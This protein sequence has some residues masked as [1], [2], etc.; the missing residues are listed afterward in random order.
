MKRIFLI[1]LLAIAVACASAPISTKQTVVNSF[2][3][4]T[5][6]L[7]SAQTLERSY[8]FNS[9]ATES[10]THCTNPLAAQIKLTDAL[11]VRMATFFNDAFTIAIAA[12][13][14]LIAWQPGSPT[15]TTVT[16]YLAD[17]TTLL[18][19][20]QTLDPAAAPLVSQLQSAANTG[21]TIATSLGVK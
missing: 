16:Q 9:P 7:A 18:S 20:V 4:T 19:T 1:P 6:F 3:A 10:G 12:G 8:C 2:Q 11:H 14:A 13:P 5:N 17:V 15:P 21:A